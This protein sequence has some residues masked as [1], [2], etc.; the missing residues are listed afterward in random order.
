M[1]RVAL[2][3]LGAVVVTPSTS[4][5]MR[6]LKRLKYLRWGK[7]NR[8]VARWTYLPDL[9]RDLPDIEMGGVAPVLR[10]FVTRVREA[11]V[12][13]DGEIDDVFGPEKPYGFQRDAI[14]FTLNMHRVLVAD[15]VGLGKSIEAIGVMGILFARREITRAVLV[16]PAGLKQQWFEEVHRFLREDVIPGPV[17][18]VTAGNKRGRHDLYGRSWSVLIINPELVRLDLSALARVTDIGLVVLDEASC[19]RNHTTSIAR[20]MKVIWRRALYRMALTATPVENRLADLFSVFEWV[21]PSVFPSRSYFESRYVVFRNRPITVKTKRGR[22]FT[23]RKREPVKYRKLREVRA[24]IGHRYIRRRVQDVGLELPSIVVSW[25]RITLP[26]AQRDVYEALRGQAQ[27]TLKGLRGAALKA[28]LQGLRQACNSTELV[29]TSTGKATSVK[30]KR[31]QELLDTELAGE[32]VLV[33][34]DYERFVRLLVR[35]IKPRPVAYTGKMN[36]RERQAALDSFRDDVRVM[37]ATK[38]GERG[39]NLQHA[40]VVVNLDLPWNPASLKQRLGRIRRIGSEASVIRMVN[41]IA[42][43]TV[44]DR[45]IARAIYGKRLLFES[46]FDQ[47]ELSEAD[48]MSGMTGLQVGRLL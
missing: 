19:I 24:K 42:T 23:I 9:R 22:E 30:T 46:L 26:K 31:L 5:E 21:D 8:A 14:R 16:V 17:V 3:K 4:K 12:G 2:T 37:V 32:R 29:Q 35:D 7:G 28:P 34:T 27:E 38:A 36:K 10:E 20:A 13:P 33:F 44:E 18:V 40:S 11:H 45:L 6:R 43:D 1:I 15:D 48:P 39:H 41:M 25:D 47:D